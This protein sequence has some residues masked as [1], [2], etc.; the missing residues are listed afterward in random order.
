M[1][2]SEVRLMHSDL[3]FIARALGELREAVAKKKA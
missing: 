2:A 3:G 1:L